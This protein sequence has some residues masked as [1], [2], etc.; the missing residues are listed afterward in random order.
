MRLSQ[1]LNSALIFLVAAG[2]SNALSQSP[3]SYLNDTGGTAYGVNIPVENGFINIS[4]GNLHLEFPLAS[5]PK[6][7]AFGSFE[8]LTYDSR[9]WMFSPFGT[10]GS[11]HWWPYNVP[12]T[13]TSSGGWQFV[14]GAEIGTLGQRICEI[15]EKQE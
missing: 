12:G 11:Y 7:G 4:N 5:H 14:T 1:L 9:I 8:K 6:R 13:S 15:W 10:H 3:V 2:G